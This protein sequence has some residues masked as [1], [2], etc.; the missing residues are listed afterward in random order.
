MC[1]HKNNNVHSLSHTHDGL[2]LRYV[3]ADTH[4][5]YLFCEMIPMGSFLMCIKHANRYKLER[6]HYYKWLSVKFGN[7]NE[8]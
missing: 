6:D 3:C 8:D 5:L 7:F 1:L 2:S 4:V